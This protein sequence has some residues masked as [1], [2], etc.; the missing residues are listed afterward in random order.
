M[1]T[2][3]PSTT[4]G[5]PGVTSGSLHVTWS[6]ALRE[7][8]LHV[9]ATRAHKTL[10]YYDVQLRQL[11]DWSEENHVPFEEFGKRHLDRYLVHRSSQGKAQLTLHHDA[12][13]AKAFFAWCQRNDL[14]DRSRLAEYQVRNAP[15]PPRFMPSDEDMHKLLG[16]VHAFWD[17]A[18]NPDM[19]YLPA[20]KRIFHR[21]RNYAIILG[22]LDSASRIGEMLS[23][24]VGDYG[25]E[26]RQ[27]T[28]R[29]SKG[30]E[31]RIIPVSREWAEALSVWLKVRQRTMAAVPKELDDGWLFPSETG[32]RLD[33]RAF[34]KALRNYVQFGGASDSITLHSLRR[35]SLNRLAKTNL[36]AAQRIAG[37]KDTKTTL[38]Y[39]QIDADHVREVH[40]AVGVVRGVLQSKR[41]KRKRLV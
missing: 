7:F 4:L 33:E 40:E 22:L 8:L 12:V 6:E 27:I 30:R 11:I 13:C 32:N 21:D 29:E 36:L 37:H 18:K 19:R 34:L 28:I 14:I 20:P 15:R 3:F 17:P 26:Q 25:K 23:L 38:L 24:K 16:A 39:T 9:Q 1:V 2:A 5:T 35:Y 10:R 31:P 41:E